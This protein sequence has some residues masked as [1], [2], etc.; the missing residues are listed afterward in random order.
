MQQRHVASG[1]RHRMQQGPYQTE[2]HQAALAALAELPMLLHG[3]AQHGSTSI[4]GLNH[5]L[6]T[7]DSLK[8]VTM[9][10]GLA[11]TGKLHP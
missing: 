2:P 1:T 8:R 4:P 5:V 11:T 6:A 7:R 9:G 3:H 10:P